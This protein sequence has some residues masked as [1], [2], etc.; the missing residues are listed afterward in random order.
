M[1]DLIHY[2]ICSICTL[3]SSRIVTVHQVVLIRVSEWLTTET[4]K[5]LI[6]FRNSFDSVSL[7]VPSLAEKLITS[8]NFASSLPIC[9]I[10]RKQIEY[11]HL[12]IYVK[13]LD[14]LWI[15]LQLWWISVAWADKSEL[16]IAHIYCIVSL[17]SSLSR[18]NS[19]VNKWFLLF[20]S[21]N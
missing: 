19:F 7:W 9:S 10:S 6:A 3:I 15:N 1:F 20:W 5:P 16:G 12:L 21:S 11:A 4:G 18:E 14:H 17:F 13:R 2:K 8:S